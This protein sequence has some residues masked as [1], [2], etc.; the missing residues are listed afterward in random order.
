[1]VCDL[2]GHADSVF[3]LGFLEDES[4]LPQPLSIHHLACNPP[5]PKLP[6]TL[7]LLHSQVGFCCTNPTKGIGAR[8][9]NS[10]SFN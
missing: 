10:K 1:M 9:D 8:L 4:M 2:K 6:F 7:H 3:G 5:F